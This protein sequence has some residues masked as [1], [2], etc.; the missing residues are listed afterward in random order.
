MRGDRDGIVNEWGMVL[1]LVRKKPHFLGDGSNGPETF[2]SILGRVKKRKKRN[3][4]RK[5]ENIE[6]Q[7]KGIG[8]IEV[9]ISWLLVGRRDMRCDP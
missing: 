5:R 1:C 9:C 3:G 2:M 6:K 4:W 7:F 8:K